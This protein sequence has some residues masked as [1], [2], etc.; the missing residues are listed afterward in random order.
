MIALKVIDANDQQLEAD[1]E[2]RTYFI[3]LSWNE[4]GEFWTLSLRDA[5][6]T[7]LIY[8]V[9]LVPAHPLLL[10]YRRPEFPP[11]EIAVSAIEPRLTRQSFK[12]GAAAL[13]YLTRAEMLAGGWKSYA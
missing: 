9:P 13:L 8:G 1:L 4:S 3:R 11:G 5:A 10:Q 6:D 12:D 2:G 7:G